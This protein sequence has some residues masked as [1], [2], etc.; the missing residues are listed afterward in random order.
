MPDE[1]LRRLRRRRCCDG[2]LGMAAGVFIEVI[3]KDMLLS[4]PLGS[5]RRLSSPRAHATAAGLASPGGRPG[6][7]FGRSRPGAGAL[8]GRWKSS[9]I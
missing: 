8:S 9:F 4:V 2:D 1:V 6:V 3:S 5:P 7:Y